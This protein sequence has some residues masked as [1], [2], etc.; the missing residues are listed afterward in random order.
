MA[1]PYE[2]ITCPDPPYTFSP[3]SRAVIIIEDGKPRVFISDPD[4][5]KVYTAEACL[6]SDITA[7][8]VAV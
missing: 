2:V 6:L 7:N 5:D 4:K 8:T 1:V 3:N